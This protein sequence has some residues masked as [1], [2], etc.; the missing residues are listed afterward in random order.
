VWVII[1]LIQGGL[2]SGPVLIQ[3]GLKS[4]TLLDFEMLQRDDLFGF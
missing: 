2:N 4:A 3:G 1:E